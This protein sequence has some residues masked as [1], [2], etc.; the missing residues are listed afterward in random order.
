MIAH[1]LSSVVDADKVVVMDGGQIVE[2]GTHEQLL[3][4]EG[5]AY[6]QMWNEYQESI[7]WTI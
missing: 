2:Q 4:Q 6:A 1:R 3:Q 7:E 5:S